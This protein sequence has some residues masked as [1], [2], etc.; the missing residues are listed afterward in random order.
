MRVSS[1]IA[2]SAAQESVKKQNIVGNV[3]V[4]L[5]CSI[6]IATGSITVLEKRTTGTIQALMGIISNI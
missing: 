6:I 5:K 2:K 4:V 1:I 3:I